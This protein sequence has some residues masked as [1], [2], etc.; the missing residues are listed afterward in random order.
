MN[1]EI[2]PPP[3]DAAW[4]DTFCRWLYSL[5]VAE[6]ANFKQKSRIRSH[7]ARDPALGPGWATFVNEDTYKEHWSKRV[8]D[9]EVCICRCCEVYLLT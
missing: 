6:D 7:D 5:I 3:S 1:G 4:A 9:D 2:W 8:D